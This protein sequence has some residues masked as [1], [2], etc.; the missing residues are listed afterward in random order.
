MDLLVSVLIDMGYEDAV[1][2]VRDILVMPP[3]RQ[4]QTP[5]ETEA[6]IQAQS[7]F[8]RRL[9]QT[10][11]EI[12]LKR[13]SA[14]LI[15]DKFAMTEKTLRRRFRS[16]L[17]TT[18][19]RWIQAQRIAKAKEM[20][21]QSS[22]PVSEICRQVGYDDHASFVRLFSRITGVTPSEYRQHIRI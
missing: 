19:S 13:A 15:A 1:R 21:G 6:P 2:R 3:I 11:K 5:Y 22:L 18:P 17:D 9:G 7:D 10:V 4:L 20:L 8:E 12:G 16:E 14:L